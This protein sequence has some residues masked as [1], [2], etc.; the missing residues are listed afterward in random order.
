MY[1]AYWCPHCQAQKK[2]FG[3]SFQYVPY[4]ECTQQNRAVS[5]KKN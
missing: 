1:G 4:V 5:R 3:E 2:V